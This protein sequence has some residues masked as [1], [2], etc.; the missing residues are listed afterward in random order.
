MRRFLVLVL[1]FVS[2][3]GLMSCS[4]F[5]TYDG[6]EVTQVLIVKETRRMYLLHHEEVLATY[7][8]NLGFAPVGDK[9]TRGDGKTPEGRYFIDRKNPKSEFHLSLGINYPN[10][11]DRYVARAAGVN[12]GNNI[13]IHGGPTR[14]RDRNRPDWT[15]GCIAVSNREIEDVYAM[16]NVGTPVLIMP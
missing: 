4:K 9:A 15:A 6:P 1:V 11:Q 13:F 14:S 2:A 5:K 3:F 7:A 8:I 12:P 10:A 16:V